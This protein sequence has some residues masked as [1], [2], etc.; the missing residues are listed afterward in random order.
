MSRLHLLTRTVSTV[1][2]AIEFL[3][4]IL[5]LGIFSYFL[6]VLARRDNAVIPQWQKAV[7]GLSGAAALFTLLAVIM[8]CFLGGITFFAFLAV[9]L[10]VLFCAAMIA[11]AIMTKEGRRSCSST[12]DNSPIG[13]GHATSCKLQNVV[14][15]V[16]ILGAY[17]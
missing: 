9:L 1:L 2:Y 17:V 10:D 15:A 7:E 12:G 11:I 6:A 4:S 16:S 3:I 5:I 13:V 14:F 8:T